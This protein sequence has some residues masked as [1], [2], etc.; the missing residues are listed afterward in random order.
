MGN[1]AHFIGRDE[2]SAKEN[3]KAYAEHAKRNF[4]S[5]KSTGQV[6][7]GISPRSRLEEL[8]ARLKE[9]FTLDLFETNRAVSLS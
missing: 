9:L 8:K 2:L 4:P 3:L 5:K 6:V 7:A 1:I